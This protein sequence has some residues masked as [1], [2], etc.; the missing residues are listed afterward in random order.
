M[1]NPA[2]PPAVSSPPRSDCAAVRFPILAL[3]ERRLSPALGYVFDTRWLDPHESILSI[4]WKFAKA[5][6]IP[7]HIVASQLRANI[8]PYEGVE[9]SRTGLDLRR[10]RQVLA[11][12]LKTLRSSFAPASLSRMTSGCLRYCP[13]CMSRGYHCVVH[14]FHSLQC[15][16]IHKTP[17]ELECRFC[18][19]EASYRLSALILDA[20]YR[21]PQCRGRYGNSGFSITTRR[22]LSKKAQIIMGRIHYRHFCF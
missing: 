10:L 16:P 4:L 1:F 21:C 17:L 8:D 12:P 11:V 20:P 7:G 13:I 9:A 14:Q 3:D 15:C 19:H 18:G 5:N 2:V 6:A 22:P